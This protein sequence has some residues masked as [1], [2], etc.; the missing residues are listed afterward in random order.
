MYCFWRKLVPSSDCAAKECVNN[1]FCSQCGSRNVG[2]EGCGGFNFVVSAAA[3][4]LVLHAAIASVVS[5]AA[6][7]LVVQAVR[8]SSFLP[9]LWFQVWAP[10]TFFS[11]GYFVEHGEPG[12]PALVF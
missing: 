2:T 5:A 12:V 6:E 10:H 11:S 1:C 4:M 7:T 8:A 3:K 9:L